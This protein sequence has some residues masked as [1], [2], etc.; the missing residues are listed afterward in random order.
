MVAVFLLMSVWAANFVCRGV[1]SVSAIAAV[2]FN[3]EGNFL[4][5]VSAG[6]GNWL[7]T[8]IT[9]ICSLRSLTLLLHFVIQQHQ[10]DAPSVC[11]HLCHLCLIKPK[12]S[13]TSNSDFRLP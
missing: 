5:S 12:P 4:F 7:R 9:S 3:A 6:S 10:E 2:F 13:M 11:W 8:V 1:S